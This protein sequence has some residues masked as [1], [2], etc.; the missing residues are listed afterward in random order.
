MQTRS[1]K[2]ELLPINNN[3]HRKVQKARQP[4]TAN[5]EH[6][7][8]ALQVVMAEGAPRDNQRA[9]RDY[10]TPRINELQS[11]ITRPAIAA[12]SFEIK[13]GTI[14]MVQNS[15]QFG[16]M[17]ND[18][19]NEHLMSFIEICETFKFNGVSD[20]AV[21]LRLFPFTLRDKARSW[22]HSLPPGSITT[23]NDLAQKFLAKFFP[24]A[25]TAKL[26]NDISTFEQQHGES[27]YEAW[28]RYKELLRRCPHHGLPQWMQI[29][30]FYNGLGHQT[31]S[32][33]DAA[34]GGAFMAKNYDDDYD[35]L[36]TM[37]ANNYQW[38]SSR[39]KQQKAPG[40]IEVDA[41][42]ALTA[43]MSAMSKKIESMAEGKV[44]QVSFICELCAGAHS[45][46][47]CAINPEAVNFVGNSYQR[48]PQSY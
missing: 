38:P 31:R 36:E 18:D 32:S 12:N 9:L 19:P 46:D 16:G 4:T 14:Q 27:L 22:L 39:L 25:R 2:P 34:S 24:P 47:Q 28:E 10:A 33:I 6:P 35:L 11:S 8:A 42:T 21:R 29:N 26:R 23:W 40:V 48:Q 43:Q 45:T 7:E 15:V 41:I 17:A 13:P 37:A 5:Q 20:D 44:Q 3:I 1:H 30:T